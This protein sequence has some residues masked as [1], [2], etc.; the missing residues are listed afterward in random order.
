MRVGTAWSKVILPIVLAF[1]GASAAMAQDPMLLIL[2]E[3]LDLSLLNTPTEGIVTSNTVSPTD[4]TVPSL[5][6][7]D[8]QFGND[9]LLTWIAFTEADDPLR[10][11]DLIVDPQAWTRYSYIDRYAFIQH[12]GTTATSF[13]YNLRVFNGREELLGAY[14]CDPAAL[15][16]AN[17]NSEALLGCRVFLNSYG[18]VPIGGLNPFAVP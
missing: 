11:V 2:T 1:S 6:W 12:F 18:Q 10:R 16:A 17:V 7:A 14:L 13:G 9:L 3:P 5:W 8:E 15:A 4:L